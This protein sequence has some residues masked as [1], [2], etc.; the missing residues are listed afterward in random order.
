MKLNFLSN[1]RICSRS[2]AAAAHAILSPSPSPASLVAADHEAVELPPG[3]EDQPVPELDFGLDNESLLDFSDEHA[4]DEEEMQLEVD[5]KPRAA[6]P[7]ATSRFR[8]SLLCRAHWGIQTIGSAV[9]VLWRT[10]KGQTSV[11][12]EPLPLDSRGYRVVL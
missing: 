4:S 10:S 8:C 11:K 12:T 9:C 6:S 5:V 1:F 7:L 2:T 3:C